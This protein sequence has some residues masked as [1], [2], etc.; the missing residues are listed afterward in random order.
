MGKTIPNGIH[1]TMVTPFTDDDKIDYAGVER[2]LQWYADHQVDG[3]FALCQSSEIFYLT[4]QEKMELLRFIVKNKPE[5]ITLIASGHTSDDIKTQQKEAE[6]ISQEGIDAYVFIS[7]R[8]AAQHEDDRTFLRN[9]KEVAKATEGIPLGIYEC[10][11]PYK[12][13]LSPDV[14]T[15]LLDIGDFQFLKDTS[16][17]I[18]QMQAKLAAMSGSNFK[19]FNANSATLLESLRIGAHGFSGVMANFH[20]EL[21]QALFGNFR[22]DENLAQRIQDFIGCFSLVEGQIYPTNAKYYLGTM[23]GLGFG[24]HTRSKDPKEFTHNRQLEIQQMWALTQNWKNQD[25][26]KLV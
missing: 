6:A 18:Q 15:A 22:T 2:L 7:N 25:N 5:G 10:P 24:Y 4:F 3:I 11:Y 8:F 19:L 23:E 16:C 21:Y 12:R 13:L 26:M 1:V 9:A 20:P 14:L 17:D